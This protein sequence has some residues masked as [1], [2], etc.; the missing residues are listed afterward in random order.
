MNNPAHAAI[1]ILALTL[2]AIGAAHS[3]ML[4]QAKGGYIKSVKKPPVTVPGSCDLVSTP[5]SKEALDWC[6]SVSVIFQITGAADTNYKAV[7][8]V[9]G[10]ST[11]LLGEQVSKTAAGPDGFGEITVALTPAMK[12]DYAYVILH[13]DN[14]E[15]DQIGKVECAASR[16]TR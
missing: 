5:Y 14:V 15:Y 6:K 13:F 1:T 16:I 11:S 9:W 12:P 3:E 4:T 10:R 2:A 7:C 8:R